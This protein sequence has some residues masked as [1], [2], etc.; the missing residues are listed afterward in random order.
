MYIYELNEWMKIIEKKNDNK[1]VELNERHT[2]IKYNNKNQS[3]L[4]NIEFN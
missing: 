3:Q 1:V 2:I 4:N